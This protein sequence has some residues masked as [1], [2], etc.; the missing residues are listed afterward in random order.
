MEVV[1]EEPRRGR[2]RWTGLGLG[3]HRLCARP[4]PERVEEKEER[5]EKT[6]ASHPR[7]G[8]EGE[9]PTTSGD[10]EAT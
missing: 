9:A 5:K 1:R 6:D 3:L 8:A 10:A 2:R 7:G 4:I